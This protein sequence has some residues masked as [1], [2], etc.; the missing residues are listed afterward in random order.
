MSFQNINYSKRGLLPPFKEEKKKMAFRVERRAPYAYIS[1][2]T[3][4]GFSDLHFVAGKHGGYRLTFYTSLFSWAN[5]LSLEPSYWPPASK[6]TLKHWLD[7][8][9][10]FP[11]R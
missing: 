3:E 4:Y 8:H 1:A 10:Q 2:R 6:I 11:L 9:E 5:Y 7:Y